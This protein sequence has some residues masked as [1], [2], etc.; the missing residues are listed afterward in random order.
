MRGCDLIVC[1]GLWTLFDAQHVLHTLEHAWKGLNSKHQVSEK[2]RYV[3]KNKHWE[4]LWW[5]FF[6]LFACIWLCVCSS[7]LG[8]FH[9]G[10]ILERWNPPVHH[11]GCQS[12]AGDREVFDILH[13]VSWQFAETKTNFSFTVQ[14]TSDLEII[15]IHMHLL[16]VPQ[17]LQTFKKV[18]I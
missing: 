11:T 3:K 9:E 6:W 7:L 10:Q 5:V 13:Y 1:C 2:H 17:S 16:W 4:M 8:T 15:C 18:N 12:S 14:C